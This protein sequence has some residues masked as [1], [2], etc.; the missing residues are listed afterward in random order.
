MLHL[1]E[2]RFGAIYKPVRERINAADARTLLIWG[3]RILT[4]QSIDEVFKD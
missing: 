2:R 1:L 4:V 3:E